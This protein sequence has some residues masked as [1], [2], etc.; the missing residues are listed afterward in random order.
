LRVSGRA[1][2]TWAEVLRRL[3]AAGWLPTDRDPGGRSWARRI[4]SDDEMPDELR[5]FF[6]TIPITELTPFPYYALAPTFR[7]I[8]PRP[9]MAKLV[10]LAS[11]RLFVA[12][13][14]EA[15]VHGHGYPLDGI[16]TLEQGVV[17][18]HSWIRIQAQREDGDN[19]ALEFNLD[20]VTDRIMNP[21]IDGLRAP[22]L[23]RAGAGQ[24][25]WPGLSHLAPVNVKFMNHAGASLRP[26]DRLRP[27]LYQPEIRRT[28]A[29]LGRVKL[30]RRMSSAQLVLVT[31]SELVVLRDDEGQRPHR[32]ARYAAIRTY[33]PLQRIT[34]ANVAP[35]A[36]DLLALEISIQ[37]A[38]RLRILFE[39][40]NEG[41]FAQVLREHEC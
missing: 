19:A 41:Q 1:P 35:V 15:A 4:T 8:Y 7:G 33:A 24:G 2:P 22:P 30:A 20:S 34:E 13:A 26:G 14:M 36:A 6:R 10:I 11:R 28:V 17:L 18:L 21:F 38:T 16:L 39:P 27:S 32:G 31:H 5:A 9:E 3:F 40:A 12:E 23:G 25:D 29:G 37:G